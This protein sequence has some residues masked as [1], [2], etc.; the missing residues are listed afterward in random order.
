MVWSMRWKL[1]GS[2]KTS[3]LGRGVCFLTC[4]CLVLI[5]GLVV[6]ANES[7]DDKKVILELKQRYIDFYRHRRHEELFS[8]QREAAKQQ[9][10]QDL[11]KFEAKEERARQQYVKTRTQRKDYS[12]P[13]KEA[14]WLKRVQHREMEY[15]KVRNAFAA[16]QRRLNK[17]AQGSYYIPPGLEYGLGTVQHKSE[18]EILM[19]RR[20]ELQGPAR[21]S[22]VGGGSDSRDD[23]LSRPNYQEESPPSNMEPPPVDNYQD[24]IPPPSDGDMDNGEP[25]N[26]WDF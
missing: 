22:G 5:V 6:G 8:R 3:F 25:D 23:R 14:K 2:L 19:R 11:K 1:V 18:G 20:R 9:Y 21:S 15:D 10:K 24:M 16:N 7:S 12:S 26:V 17:L 4:F 13:E